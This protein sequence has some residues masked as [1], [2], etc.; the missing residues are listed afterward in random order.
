MDDCTPLKRCSKCK[1]EFPATSE[2]FTKQSGTIDGLGWWCRACK[3][4]YDRQYGRRNRQRIYARQ[5][6]WAES[7]EHVPPADGLKMCSQCGKNK[8]LHEFHKY[9]QSKDGY[10]N[11]CKQC[12]AEREGF[13]YKPGAPEGF[14][15]CSSCGN[16]LPATETFFGIRNKVQDKLEGRCRD[17]V[18]KSYR[19][20][21]EANPEKVHLAKIKFKDSGKEKVGAQRWR[22]KNG[23]QYYAQ[24]RERF[25]ANHARRMA[26]KRALPDTLTAEQWKR[27]LDYLGHQCAVCGRMPG[28]WHTLA[29]DHWIPLS[30]PDC[31]GTIA[32][33]IVPLCHGDGGCNE[34]KAAR[35]PE[36]WLIEKFGKRKGRQILKR[37]EQYFEWVKEQGGA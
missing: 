25:I 9:Q 7:L 23:K 3:S 27:C 21:R 30:S 10:R 34:M 33:N 14:K 2:Y 36:E 6:R 28:L 22:E 17:C 1:R 11:I 8:P 32:T 15:R 37:I 26:R 12:R 4:E 18:R 20:W 5:R 24:N 35:L 29:M 31:P 19:R 13:K 16:I